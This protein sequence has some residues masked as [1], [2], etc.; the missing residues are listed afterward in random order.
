M[1]VSEDKRVALVTGAARGIGQRVALTLAE[2]GYRIAANDLRE[3][4]AVSRELQQAEAEALSV[5][6]DVSEEASVRG[7]VETVMEEFG[8]IDVLVT[9]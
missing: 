2:R 6:G 9:A 5:P 4:E 3:L 1:E 7:M 8:R